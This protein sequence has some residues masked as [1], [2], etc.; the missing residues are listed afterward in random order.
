[1]LGQMLKEIMVI[2][3]VGA[4]ELM[5]EYKNLLLN[6]Y[7]KKTVADFETFDEW[8]EYRYVDCSST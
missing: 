7:G 8:L 6:V 4:A 3:P 5:T 1:M 2:D